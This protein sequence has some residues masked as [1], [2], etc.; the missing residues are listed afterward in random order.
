MYGVDWEALQDDH[1]QHS[2]RSNN[3]TSEG[4]SSWIGQQG[5][6]A[7]LN[8]V[9]VLS[10]TSG[11]IPQAHIEMIGWAV[12]LWGSPLPVDVAKAWNCG[13]AAVQSIGY[14]MF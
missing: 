6:P 12:A 4:W 14:N 13:L 1:L 5:P 9:S 3:G 10:P 2:Q 11:T 7:Q 8:E